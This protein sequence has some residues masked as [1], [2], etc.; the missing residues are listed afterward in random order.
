MFHVHASISDS[1]LVG[2][3]F[4]PTIALQWISREMIGV[5]TGEFMHYGSDHFV[6]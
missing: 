6:G 3:A 1:Q 5:A 4:L 2:W